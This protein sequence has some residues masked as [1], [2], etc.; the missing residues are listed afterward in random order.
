MEFKGFLCEPPQ[1]LTLHLLTKTNF[2]IYS[3]IGCT[4]G[5]F[6]DS[7]VIVEALL[8]CLIVVEA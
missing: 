1:L 5:R 2:N 6:H 3:S 4:L 7:F 8:L